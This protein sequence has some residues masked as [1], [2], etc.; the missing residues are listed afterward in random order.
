[1]REKQPVMLKCADA[2]IIMLRDYFKIPANIR[3]MLLYNEKSK[4]SVF[5]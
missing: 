4:K 5:N 1:M 2:V 3:N